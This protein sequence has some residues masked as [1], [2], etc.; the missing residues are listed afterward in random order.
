MFLGNVKDVKEENLSN[1]KDIVKTSKKLLISEKDGA[2]NF[3]LRYFTVQPGGHTPWHS[4]D[5]EH[6]NYFV[7]GKGV[8]V[9]EE[10]EYEVCPDMFSY[11][12]PGEK[13]QYKNPYSEPFSFLCLIPVPENNNT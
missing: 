6:E 1:G 9:T 10:G 2:P 11:V 4:H 3:R 5:W 7:E 13:H 8:L 12:A